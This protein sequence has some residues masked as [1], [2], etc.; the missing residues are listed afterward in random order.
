MDQ[1]RFRTGERINNIST[2]TFQIWET[3]VRLAR[4]RTL[5]DHLC[6]ANDENDELIYCLREPNEPID[7]TPEDTS[8]E[9][10]PDEEDG[11]INSIIKDIRS[12]PRTRG[13]VKMIFY[14]RLAMI[15][16]KLTQD[17]KFR[18]ENAEFFDDL[19]LVLSRM[20]DEAAEITKREIMKYL[21]E[22]KERLAKNDRERQ[23]LIQQQQQ[24]YGSS[25]SSSGSSLAGSSS[26][27][28]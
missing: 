12:R 13:A 4:I 22:A 17:I 19:E 28:F 11:S 5:M 25:P 24:N 16:D 3:T 21:A 1:Q 7:D 23:Q 9:T 2:N 27:T 18:S 15:S 6:A 10:D 26:S 8:N 20:S 14:N